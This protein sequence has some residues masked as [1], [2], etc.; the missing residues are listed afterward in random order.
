MPLVP[1]MVSAGGF[2]RPS[3][4][5]RLRHLAVQQT[6]SD[7]EQVLAQTYSYFDW[8][9]KHNQE[10][11]H[12][13]REPGGGYTLFVPTD[14]AISNL[15]QEKLDCMEEASGDE[16]LRP[17]LQALAAFHFVQ[18]PLTLD[19]ILCEGGQGGVIH[20]AGGDLQVQI[21]TGGK[22]SV[23]GVRVSQ[24]Y[25][26]VDTTTGKRAF[27][28]ETDGLL[29][30]DEVWDIL[31]DH[32]DGSMP[33]QPREFIARRYQ[34]EGLDPLSGGQEGFGAILPS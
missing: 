13:M 5:T 21:G 28:H 1:L 18:I 30:P 26:F 23:N 25:S 2:C 32:R 34:R 33:G 29:C 16:A 22:L 3:A 11:A 14:A 4:S 31:Y 7:A 6:T 20:T 19:E 8:I 27:L 12:H 15:G 17:V 24:S 9:L 10:I